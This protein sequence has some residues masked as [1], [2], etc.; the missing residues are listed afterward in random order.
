MRVENWPNKLNK[1]LS[2]AK[3]K[4]FCWGEFD[5]FMWTEWVVEKITGA[6]PGHDFCKSKGI[7]AEP[8][9]YMTTKGMQR[10]MKKLGYTDFFELVCAIYGKPISPK[11]AQRGDLVMVKLPGVFM[12]TLGICRGLDVI[13]KT[14]EGNRYIITGECAHAWRVG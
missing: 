6:S 9:P 2:E 7:D 4:P 13:F 1:A 11:K 12:P 3:N 10:T 5:C 8:R 14:N